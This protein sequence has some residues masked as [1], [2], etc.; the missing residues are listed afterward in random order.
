MRKKL[1]QIRCC[2]KGETGFS[3]I[4]V[5]ISMAVMTIGLVG[6]LGT[7]GIAMAST[8]NSEQ[9][10]IAKRLANE[11][12]ESILTARETTQVGWAQITNGT[13]S[14][15][16]TCGIFPSGPQPINN[17]GADG[18]IGTNDDAAAG[19]QILDEPGPS[20]VIQTAVGQ[21]C[22]SAVDVCITLSNFTRTITITPVSVNGVQ[23]GNLN[24]V[25][26]TVTY[27][28]PQFKAPQNYTVATLISSYR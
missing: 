21:P 11:A 12:M 27:T 8:Q 3:L 7:L 19:P 4:E 13:C 1:C 17:P 2:N 26:I 10:A 5:L 15:G 16:G 18:I 28:N 9:L 22:N 23:D 6:L 24:S 20:G 25:V 14:I